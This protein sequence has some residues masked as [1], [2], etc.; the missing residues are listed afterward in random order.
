MKSSSHLGAEQSRPATRARFKL[1]PNNNT[2]TRNGTEAERR[3]NTLLWLTDLPI[4]TGTG[5][6]GLLRH[7]GIFPRPV[8]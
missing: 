5:C 2:V 8:G 6:F 3:G 1:P 7:P 4:A